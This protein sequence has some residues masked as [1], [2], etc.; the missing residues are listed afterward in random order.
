MSSPRN[1]VAK[2]AIR[3]KLSMAESVLAHVIGLCTL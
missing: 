3:G 1:K 2:L